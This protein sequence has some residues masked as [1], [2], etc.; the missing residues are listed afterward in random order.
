MINAKNIYSNSHITWVCGRSVSQILTVIKEIDNLVV[1]DDKKLL[2]GN[3]FNK[4]IVVI[5]VWVKLIF[6][7]YDLIIVAHSD[8]RYRIL[9]FPLLGK[10]KRYFSWSNPNNNMNPNRHHSREYI[11][12]MT[13]KNDYRLKNYT[14]SY[15]ILPL[16]KKDFD[17]INF[18]KNVIAIAPGG[19][20]NILSE[21]PLR[22]WPVENYIEV[23]DF[24]IKNGYQVLLIGSDT[25]KWLNEKFQH[26]GIIN[27]I[28]KT[29]LQELI[30]LFDKCNY[31]ITHDSGPL[32]L[33]SLTSTKILGLFGPT[34]PAIFAP[35]DHDGDLGYRKNYIFWGGLSLPCRP[36][37]NGKKFAE[38]DNNLCMQDITVK[39]IYDTIMNE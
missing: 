37:Y 38:C 22:R 27:L 12:L 20:N 1:L 18:N 10:I 24:F 30:S 9:T 15:P 28:N 13:N 34:T 33:A 35:I 4:I 32:H 5:K 2:R 7:S 11:R 36:C 16:N 23:A 21:Q 8:Y 3:I 19:T 31:V 14:Y 17:Q 25:D 29:N 39:S 6:N 26:L